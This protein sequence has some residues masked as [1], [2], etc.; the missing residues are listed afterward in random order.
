M[1]DFT[2]E[3]DPKTVLLALRPLLIPVYEA[4]EL[5]IPKAIQLVAENGWDS[6]GHLVSHLIRAEAKKFLKDR[7]CPIEIDDIPRTLTMEQIAMEGLSTKF[8]GIVVKVLKGVEIP[9]A[10]SDPR[11]EFY[12]HVDS[13]LWV[14]GQVPPIRGLLVLW[15]CTDD[16]K[17]L[18]LRLCCTKDSVASDYWMETVPHPASWMI[19]PTPPASP[20]DDLDDLVEVTVPIAVTN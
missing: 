6:S 19:T 17:N 7:P 4:L 16:G 13:Q 9:R 10:T 15:D 8:D 11:R 5:A 3:T 14:A 2:L 1:H 18:Q 20:T 12:Q